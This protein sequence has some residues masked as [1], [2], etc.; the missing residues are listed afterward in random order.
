M[1]YNSYQYISTATTTQVVTGSG[2]LKRIV[3]TETAAGTITI[4]DETGSGTTKVIAVLK[5]SIGENT[6]NFDVTF[7]T[8]LKI[9]T[10][11]ASKLTV[12]YTK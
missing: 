10:A 9:V 6:Y 2:V 8:G 12:V 3:L 4:Y 1:E 5:A 11:G 7:G